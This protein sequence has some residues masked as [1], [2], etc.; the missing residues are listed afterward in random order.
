MQTSRII[1]PMANALTA[2]FTGTP[3]EVGKPLFEE[4]KDVLYGF[5]AHAESADEATCVQT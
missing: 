4:R 2:F 5:S 3:S 1:H